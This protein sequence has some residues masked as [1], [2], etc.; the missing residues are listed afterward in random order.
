MSYMLLPYLVEVKFYCGLFILV[1]QK[2]IN[3]RSDVGMY[4]FVHQVFSA[5]KVLDKQFAERCILPLAAI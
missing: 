1:L 2:L 4:I 5:S 3:Y